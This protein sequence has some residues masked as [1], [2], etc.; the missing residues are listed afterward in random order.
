VCA[1]PESGEQEQGILM[2]TARIKMRWPGLAAIYRPASRAGK[3]K[4][5]ERIKNKEYN[6]REDGVDGFSLSKTGTIR[7]SES[8][9]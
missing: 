1:V 3:D 6:E 4:P 7:F 2:E 9:R 5:T 8:A